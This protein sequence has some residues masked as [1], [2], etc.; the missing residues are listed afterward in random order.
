MD[1]AK[2]NQAVKVIKRIA[3]ILAIPVLCFGIMELVCIANG[4]TLFN[5]GY[6]TLQLF[7]RGTTFV[8]LLSLGV[9][10]NMHTGRFD[11]S[12]GAVMLISGVIGAKVAY[13]LN[14]GPAGMMAVAA[15]AGLVIG[16]L[17]GL[18]YILLKL[19]PMIIGLGMA[20]ILEGVVAIITDG[21]QPVKFGTD[22]SYYSFTVNPV[23]LLIL[24]ALG[25]GVMLVIFHF[26]KFGYDYRAL[27]TGQKIAVNTGVNEKMNALGCYII[28]GFLFGIAGA[29]SICSTNGTTP[30]INFST[31]G[32]MFSC[33]LPLFFSGFIGKFI[34]KQVAIL[35]S[36]ISYEFIQ[37]GFGQITF[38]NAAFTTEI[39][40]VVEAVILVAFL[41]YLNNEV[42]I[43]EVV[44]FKKFR[45]KLK[46]KKIETADPEG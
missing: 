7:L 38:K 26:T 24:M 43:V 22:T 10:I 27:Q 45:E 46:A 32:T 19:P 4:I 6:S 20:L 34:N 16:G 2:N 15:V 9:S 8:F 39:R 11:F 40:S 5:G 1:P 29:L 36:C 23:A 3:G 28:A 13:G 41:I 18:L 17:V 14:L 31:I 42:K 37:I 33:F 12:T 44:M 35:L 21:C 25:L 30:T